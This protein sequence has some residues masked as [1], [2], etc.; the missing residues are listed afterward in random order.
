MA[1]HSGMTLLALSHALLGPMMPRR[2]L[3]N[4]PSAAHDILLQERLPQNVCPVDPIL[5]DPARPMA[6]KSR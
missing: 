4:P 1:H 2:F 6:K 5:R 3:R